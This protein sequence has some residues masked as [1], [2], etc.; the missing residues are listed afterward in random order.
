MRGDPQVMN[1]WQVLFQPVGFSSSDGARKIYASW[2]DYCR[3]HKFISSTTYSQIPDMIMSD[4]IM[5]KQDGR[6]AKIT[7]THYDSRKSKEY[8]TEAGM[9]KM[10]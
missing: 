9:K 8:R 7:D 10:C 2:P 3:T 6:N 4:E 1:A 5:Q